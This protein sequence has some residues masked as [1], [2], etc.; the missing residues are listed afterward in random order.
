VCIPQ[1]ET[2]PT[3]IHEL[4]VTFPGRP[5]PADAGDRLVLSLTSSAAMA[6]GSSIHVLSGSTQFNSRI[7]LNGLQVPLDTQTYL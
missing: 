7:T 2:L 3:G 6:P 4:Q 1:P 5:V